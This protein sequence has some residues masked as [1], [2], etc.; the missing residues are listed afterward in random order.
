M[1]AALARE[2][3][4]TEARGAGSGPQPHARQELAD[5]TQ[6]AVGLAV[7][8]FGLLGC[9]FRIFRYGQNLPLWSDECF[10]AVNF[11]RRGYLE[12][13]GPLENGQI[14]PI[15]FLWVQRLA[16]ALL[17]F[18]EW[19]LRLFPLA[20]GLLSVILFCHLSRRVHESDPVSLF[21]A[22]GIFAVSVHPIRH[23]A[24]AKPYAA[25]LLV[26][27]ILL[28]L[29]VEWLH[30]PWRLG[31][32]WSLTAAVPLALGLSNPAIFVVAGV[33]IGLLGPVWWGGRG[34]AR[35][36]YCILAATIVLTFA[37]LYLLV[38]RPQS[39]GAM[40]GLRQYWAASFP[41]LADPARLVAWLV[42]V[43]TGSAFAY[44]GG[45]SAGLST[46]TAMATLAGASSM[47]RRG[48][49]A[50]VI[51]LLA[52]F[53]FG[54]LAA[55][56]R[57]YPYGTEARMMQFVAPAICLLTGRGAADALARVRSD[58][59]RRKLLAGATIGL[60][61]C[62]VWP[63]VVSS[64]VPYRM[65]YDHESREYARRFWPEQSRDATLV[66][67]DLDF[68][69]APR[70]GW[71]ARK[72]WYLCNQMI[73]SPARRGA[74]G[75]DERNV[76]PEHP[77]RCV[78]FNEPLESPAARDWL[79]RMQ[80]ELT[81]KETRVFVVPVTVGEGTPAI[82]YWRTF[83]FVPRGDHPSAILAVRQA[84]RS[85]R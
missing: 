47:A 56:L 42:S 28:I 70:D 8:G 15:L 48:Q 73:Y 22:V 65:R 75:G 52:P 84:G 34:R 39:G 30:A 64:L 21:L 76:S 79:E 55:S 4:T 78:L 17:G 27:I 60:V 16:V 33:W 58:C 85:M 37:L 53:G 31:W 18:S 36:A 68:G 2:E 50:V 41:P 25:D 26:A 1:P 67:A 40:E 61:A 49:K 12:L 23:A 9:L 54:L 46:A 43:H 71:Q 81:L 13:L 45:G 72:A 32:L 24:E 77:L 62:G 80:R 20:C 59:V 10:L 51:C 57:L 6:R 35:R 29:A 69:I 63:Q 82:E 83:D 38:G 74:P 66:C 3:P 11:I 14:A 19:S 7:L 44:P 5:K